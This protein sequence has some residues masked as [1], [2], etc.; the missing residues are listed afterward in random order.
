M[1]NIKKII[2][3]FIFIL[4]TAYTGFAQGTIPKAD[5]L[6]LRTRQAQDN[7]KEIQQNAK[8]KEMKQQGGMNNASQKTKQ[9]RGGRPDMTK[10]R[11]ARP[12]MVV[13][14]SG[15]GMPKGVGKPGGAGRKGG[16]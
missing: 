11:G 2:V 1:N 3:V 13:R 16:R 5:S 7:K 15:S 9:I 14:P 4:L 12:P 6:Q 8:G 10:A